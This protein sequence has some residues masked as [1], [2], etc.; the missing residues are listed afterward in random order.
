MACFH[1]NSKSL[2]CSSIVN[3]SAERSHGE[4][5][6]ATGHTTVSRYTE[7]PP[8]DGGV[9]WHMLGGDMLQF[10]IAAD[11]TVGIQQVAKRHATSVKSRFARFATPW[12]NAA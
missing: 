9:A 3:F 11:L 7:Q 5:L 2:S 1:E 4:K 10:Q 8:D 6:V 12:Q